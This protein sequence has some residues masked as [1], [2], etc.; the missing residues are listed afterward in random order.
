MDGP[1]VRLAGPVGV[2]RGGSP[3]PDVEVGSRKARVLLALLAARRGRPVPVQGIVEAVWP[4]GAPDR[5]PRAVATLVSRLR[6]TL[7]PEAVQKIPQG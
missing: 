5:P 1:T 4:G 2:L 6:A 3:E 7:G